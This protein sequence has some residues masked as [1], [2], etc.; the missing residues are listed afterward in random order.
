MKVH[1]INKKIFQTLEVNKIIK[2][3]HILLLLKLG[4]KPSA[5]NIKPSISLSGI[6]RCRNENR[7]IAT[8]YFT[9][10]VGGMPIP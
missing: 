2:T 9:D 6:E 5:L 1:T 7:K 8:H 4:K 3:Y 10:C